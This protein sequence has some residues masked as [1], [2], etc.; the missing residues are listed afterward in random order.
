MNAA[1][2]S[3]SRVATTGVILLAAA[4]GLAVLYAATSAEALFLLTIGAGIIGLVLCV[5][6]IIISL[7]TGRPGAGRAALGVTCVIL[8][9]LLVSNI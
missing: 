5:L 8:P 2:K 4:C 3:A 6:G 7:A 9:V 1:P